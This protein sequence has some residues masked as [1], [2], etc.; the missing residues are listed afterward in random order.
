[1]SISLLTVARRARDFRP[2]TLPSVEHE[3]TELPPSVVRRGMRLGL[4]EGMLAQVHMSLTNGTLA[5]GL[6]LLLGAGSFGLGMLAAM[7]VLG[8]LLQFPTA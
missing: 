5:T 2:I 1:M 3:S 6:A 8:A 4:V 7:P